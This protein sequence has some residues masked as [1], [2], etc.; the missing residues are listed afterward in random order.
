[1]VRDLAE[2]VDP[3]PVA[4]PAGAAASAPVAIC[5]TQGRPQAGVV[6]AEEQVRVVE[7]REAA[8]KAPVVARELAAAGADPVEVAEERVS[9]AQAVP[10]AELASA[11]WVGQAMEVM[12]AEL[13][14]PA[15]AAVLAAAGAFLE[16]KAA[17]PEAAVPAVVDLAVVDLAVVDLAV[18]DPAVVDPAVEV[19]AVVDPAVEG[20]AEPVEQALAV[21]ARLAAEAQQPSLANGSRPRHLFA[22]ESWVEFPAFPECRA[23]QALVG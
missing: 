8:A 10:A 13:V 23:Q 12:V 2:A 22:A 15:R 4:A 3:E 5:G 11:V 19:L 21:A 14:G 16:A 18:V 17:V 6:A 7:V 9:A 20:Q 1:M